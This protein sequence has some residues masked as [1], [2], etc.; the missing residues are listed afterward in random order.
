MLFCSERPFEIKI[1]FIK[2][3][4]YITIQGIK[5]A[6]KSQNEVNVT[7]PIG[8]RKIMDVVK[9]KSRRIIFSFESWLP[10]GLF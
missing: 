2:S 6:K 4:I 5:F 1:G 7:Y 9:N 8:V 10:F 3:L